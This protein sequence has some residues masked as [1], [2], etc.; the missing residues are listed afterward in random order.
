MDG[1]CVAKAARWNDSEVNDRVGMKLPVN[2]QQGARNVNVLAR[3]CWDEI[4]VGDHKAAVQGLVVLRN[5]HLRDNS[6]SVLGRLEQE[7]L[8]A[9][10]QHIG[11]PKDGRKTAESL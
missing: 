7:L 1:V 3:G 5:H 10:P 11:G 4:E 9:T 8:G 2:Q 6:V